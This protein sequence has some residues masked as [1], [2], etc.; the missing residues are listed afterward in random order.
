M[1]L[2]DDATTNETVDASIGTDEDA[3]APVASAPPDADPGAAT[4]SPTTSIEQHAAKAV[5]KWQGIVDSDLVKMQRGQFDQLNPKTVQLLTKYSELTRPNGAQRSAPTATAEDDDESPSYEEIGRRAAAEQQLSALR[6][7][8]ES[9]I[10]ADEWAED[11]RDF[12]AEMKGINVEDADW[13]TIDFLNAGKFPRSR[14]GYRAWKRAIRPVLTKYAGAE[15]TVIESDETTEPPASTGVAADKAKAAATKRP[16]N[17][18]KSQIG[19][20]DVADAARRR[21]LGQISDKDY[22][23]ILYPTEHR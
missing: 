12:F 9:Q 14:E 22:L 4:D 10:V 23:K 5:Q 8:T 3:G 7:E 21:N 6:S 1:T 16:P 15:R 2:E 17:P 19:I 11:V 20:K 13:E 18:S